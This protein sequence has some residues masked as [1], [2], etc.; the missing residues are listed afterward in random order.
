MTSLK[1]NLLDLPYRWELLCYEILS[2]IPS[3]K[4]NWWIQEESTVYKISC[5]TVWSSILNEFLVAR[6]SAFTLL[7]QFTLEATHYGLFY[8]LFAL[9]LAYDY[10]PCNQCVCKQRQCGSSHSL[11]HQFMIVEC[12]CVFLIEGLLYLL[13]SFTQIV[14]TSNRDLRS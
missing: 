1:Y 9:F 5:S 7:F 10:W 13:V 12:M 6:K 3:Q 2:I 11:L 14:S 8:W 4:A